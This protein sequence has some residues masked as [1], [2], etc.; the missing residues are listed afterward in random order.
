MP[1]SF[2][3]HLLS[4]LLKGLGEAYA[5]MQ[6]A[7]ALEQQGVVYEQVGG[8]VCHAGSS[9]SILSVAHSVAGRGAR[10]QPGTFS[11]VLH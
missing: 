1:P 4:C 2:I 10:K 8:S 11:T 5:F 7:A 3:H 9:G 6:F